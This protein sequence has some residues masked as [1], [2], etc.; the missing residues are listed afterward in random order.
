MKRILI[1]EDNELNRDVLSR[2]LAA[3]GY[4]VLVAEDGLQGLALAKARQPDLILMDLGLPD[5]DGWEC[6]RRLRA[7]PAT[8]TV[9]VV[10]LT[11]HAM[12]GDR[13]KALDAGCDEFDTKPIDFANLL[14]KMRSL[15]D[16]TAAP[17]GPAR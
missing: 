14:I 10:A 8:R 1:V 11:A 4:E 12:R 2:R 9:P 7:N 17:H 6:V 13:E 15:L 3:S 5:I 16:K